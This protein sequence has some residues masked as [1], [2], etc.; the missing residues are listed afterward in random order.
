MLR[1]VEVQGRRNI[2]HGFG[3]WSFSWRVVSSSFLFNVRTNQILL[4]LGFLVRVHARVSA[5]SVKLDEFPTNVTLRRHLESLPP[6]HSLEASCTPALSSFTHRRSAL[7]HTTPTRE[8]DQHRD[9][10]DT[11]K[12]A[13]YSRT[14]ITR[15]VSHP[16]SNQRNSVC[17]H[18]PRSTCTLTQSI[19]TSSPAP[20]PYP[21]RA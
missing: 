6:R 2:A 3:T 8:P 20:S 19:S 15:P 4:E 5:P 1:F 9:E 16:V 14:R 21:N 12:D 11:R 7:S 13:P 18:P 10:P 17:H